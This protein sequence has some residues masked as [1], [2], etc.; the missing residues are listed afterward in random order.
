MSDKTPG[1]CTCTTV[2]EKY[3]FRYGSAIE[4]GS[5]WDPDSSCPVHNPMNCVITTDGADI[6]RREVLELDYGRWMGTE[7]DARPI[8]GDAPARLEARISGH[9]GGVIA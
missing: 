2:D 6:S 5:M 8:D 7:L 9:A 3:W 1:E 4:P